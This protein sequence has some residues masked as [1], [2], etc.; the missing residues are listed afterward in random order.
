MD[1]ENISPAELSARLARNEAV[2]LI[3]VRELEE[4]EI[5]RIEGA[6]LLPLSRFNEWSGTLD[7]N[8]EFVFMCH[9]GI[10]SAQVCAVLARAGFER[11]RNLTG[12]IESW[13]RDVDQSV[14][15]Y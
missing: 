11:L 13:S 9:H 7:A 15:R 4:Y 1:Y 10:R 3:D 5:A 2:N 12:G 6:R 8:E 14:P